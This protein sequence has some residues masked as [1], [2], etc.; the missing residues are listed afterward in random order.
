[1][2]APGEM[3]LL[4]RCVVIGVDLLMALSIFYLLGVDVY[5]LTLMSYLVNTRFTTQKHTIRCHVVF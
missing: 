4:A 3:F 1:M 5:E 2:N